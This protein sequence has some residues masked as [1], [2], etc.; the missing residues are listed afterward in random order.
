[1]QIVYQHGCKW[2]F[3]FNARKSAVQVF[4]E[5][6]KESKIG[7]ENR[8]FKLGNQKVKEKGYYD[9]V[10]IK[11]CMKG[12]FFVRTEERVKKA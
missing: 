6:N 7:H 11:V 1:M 3:D 9:H 10:G 12:D 4:G 2:R 8:V 5:T